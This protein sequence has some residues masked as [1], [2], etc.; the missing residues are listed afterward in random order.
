MGQLQPDHKRL[1]DAW[2]KV[3]LHLTCADLRQWKRVLIESSDGVLNPSGI[4]F[5]SAEIYAIVESPPFTTTHGIAEAFCVGRRR[6][7]DNDEAV[8]LFIRMQSG[9]RFTDSLRQQLKTAVASALSKRHVPKFIVEVD[10]IPATVNGKKVEIAVKKIISG[11]DVAV[12]STVVNPECLEGYKR[13]R[14]ME[15]E[16]R[17]NKL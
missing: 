9:H 6:P 15:V 8:F 1:G 3:S 17:E 10:E 5:G 11:K 7:S 2:A 16:A 4:R 14:Y 12:S 13:F